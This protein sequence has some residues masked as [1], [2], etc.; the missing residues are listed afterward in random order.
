MVQH[1]YERTSYANPTVL[2]LRC[3]YLSAWDT[4]VYM[5]TPYVNTLHNK[6]CKYARTPFLITYTYPRCIKQYT[7][8]ID[9]L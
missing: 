9:I 4:Y 7:Q 2:V 5:H 6:T 3:V 8:K 1:T